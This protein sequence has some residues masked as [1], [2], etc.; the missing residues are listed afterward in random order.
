MIGYSTRKLGDLD[1]GDPFPM[2]ECVP[3]IFPVDG[4]ATPMVPGQTFEYTLPDTFGR[5]WAQIWERHHED[6]MARPEEEDLFD[7]E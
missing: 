3:Q 4:Q 1:E 7:F 6:G 2:I 5:P